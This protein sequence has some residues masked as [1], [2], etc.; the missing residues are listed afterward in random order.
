MNTEFANALD[1][2]LDGTNRVPEPINGIAIDC[3]SITITGPLLHFPHVAAEEIVVLIRE[4]LE[5]H[6]KSGVAFY[7]HAVNPVINIS[8]E[9]YQIE[10][11]TI[12][13]DV[14]A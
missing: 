2:A 6:D 14:S 3:P 8:D 11:F 5:A 4:T 13:L 10:S 7:M 9:R 1:A 12:S